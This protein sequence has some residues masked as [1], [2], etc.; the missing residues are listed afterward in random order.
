VQPIHFQRFTRRLPYPLPTYA[1]MMAVAAVLLLLP[2]RPSA[3][4]GGAGEKGVYRMHLN[5]AVAKLA[6]GQPIIGVGAGELTMASCRATAR[7]KYDYAYID[8]EHSPFNFEAISQCVA[9]MVD[10]E[11]ALQK[12]NPA[13]DVALFARFPP[14]GRDIDSND[15]IAKQALDRG[16]MGILFNTLDNAEQ[17]QRA[18]Q[19]MRYPQM[20]SSKYQMPPGFRGY[21]PGDAAWAWGISTAEY[22]RHADVWPINPDGDLLMI[23]MIESQEGVRNAD[24]IAAVP[25]VGAIFLASGEDLR[26]AYGA[27]DINAPE[28]EAARQTVLRACKAHNVACGVSTRNQADTEKRLKEGWKMIRTVSGVTLPPQ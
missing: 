2:I 9:A 28:V 15:W 7:L 11:R 17:A 23:P 6:K 14:Y 27:G 10:K 19:N 18:V 4:E 3:Q 16:L 24:K 1:V 26:F 12:G 25:G 21:G 13:P 22:L 5:P 8:M 20:K